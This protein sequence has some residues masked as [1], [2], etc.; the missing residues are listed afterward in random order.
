MSFHGIDFMGKHHGF[1][2]TRFYKIHTNMVQR[3]T[4]RNL[5]QFKDYGGR[6]ISVCSGWINVRNFIEWALASG[7][8]EDLTLERVNTNDG[9]YPENCR[10]ATRKDQARNRRNSKIICGKTLSEWAEI[11]GVN[12][13]TLFANVKRGM[14][15]KDTIEKSQQNRRHRRTKEEL[16]WRKNNCCCAAGVPL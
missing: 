1:S 3:C 6:G 14:L 9:Y 5:P 2:G 13:K 15:L 7:Y 10:R 12:Y 16:M 11:S 4:N 8:R